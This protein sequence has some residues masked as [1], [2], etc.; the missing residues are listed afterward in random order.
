[1]EILL[2]PLPQKIDQ[3]DGVFRRILDDNWIKQVFKTHLNSSLL[4]GHRPCHITVESA[5]L[6]CSS[7]ELI[8][9]KNLEQIR[10]WKLLLITIIETYISNDCANGRWRN[11]I[12]VAAALPMFT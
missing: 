10:R 3:V 9:L 4:Q 1:M 11:C 5:E 7:K 12:F 6:F 8:L 2:P